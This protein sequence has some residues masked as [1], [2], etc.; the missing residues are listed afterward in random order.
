LDKSVSLIIPTYNEKDNVRPLIEKLHSV[1]AGYQYEVVFV[2]DNS[3]DGTIE[4]VESLSAK[5]P[6]RIIVRKDVRGLATAVVDG[7][8][9]AQG[10][11]FVVMD[12]D[13][14]HPPELIPNLLQ[15]LENGADMAIASRYISGG[16][17]QNWSTS[18]KII[19]KGAIIITHIL[20][21]YSRAVKD[22][23]SGFFALKREVVEGVELKPIGWKILLETLYMGKSQKVVEVPF[24]FALRTKGTSKLNFKQQIEYLK[25]IWSLMCRKGEHWRFLKFI[26]VGLSGV[27]VNEGILALVTL[28][29]NW[30]K[31]VAE[32]PGIE[33]SIITNF[34]LNDYFTFRD[35]RTGHN[36][37]YFN[38]LLRFNLVSVVGALINI[39]IYSLITGVFGLN[40]LWE[41]QLANFIGIV[42]A[43]L[44]NYFVNSW[45]TWQ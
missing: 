22:I 34:I 29:T 42:I 24:I 25:H 12:A 15:A 23:T 35:R 19:S 31:Y 2:D 20:L 44:W 13:L 43:F 8:K 27:G 7:F 18:R 5:Y 32:I 28:F 37:S 21:P 30:S 36:K 10:Q 40:N 9:Y 3:R 16:G 33:V 14:Q 41:L 1:L 39:G 4:L 38:R 6:V 11:Y 17:M 45:W 26:G